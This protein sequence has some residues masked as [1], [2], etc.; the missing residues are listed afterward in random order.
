MNDAHLA[1]Y[2]TPQAA[3]AHLAHEHPV[4][5]RQLGLR[6]LTVTRPVEV[7]QLI[8]APASHLHTEES[9]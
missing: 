9:A 2:Q 1:D 6:P 4:A 7:H 5:V 3:R 8:H